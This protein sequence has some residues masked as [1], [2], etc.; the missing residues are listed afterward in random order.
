MTDPIERDPT[1]PPAAGEPAADADPGAAETEP[2]EDSEQFEAEG[3][4]SD[5]DDKDDAAYEAPDS[6]AAAGSSVLGAER[7]ARGRPGAHQAI[8]TGPSASEAAVHVGDPASAVYVVAIVLVFIA[9]FGYAL[10]GGVGGFLTPLPTP[11]P[12]PSFGPTAV[13]SGSLAPSAVPSA[14]SAPS[15]SPGASGAASP[16]AGPSGGS[17]AASSSPAP[18][19]SVGAPSPSPAASPSS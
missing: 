15:S 9:I 8:T 18:S 11:A 1:L 14:S 4:P 3:A 5:Y 7:G 10:I 12:A 16:S 2:E 6:S 17:P 19:P 13:P